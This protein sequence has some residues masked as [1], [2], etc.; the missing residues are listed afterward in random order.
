MVQKFE[1]I[2]VTD[3]V[4]EQ[5]KFLADK[6]GKTLSATVTEIMEAVFNV[7]CTFSDLNLEYETCISDSTVL[8]SVKGKNK[9]KSGIFPVSDSM[10]EKTVDRMIKE[11]VN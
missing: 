6:S 2:R 8:I 1:A 11:K 10:T 9:L 7:A 3:K 4:H 5:V